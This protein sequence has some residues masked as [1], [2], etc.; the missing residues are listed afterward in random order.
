MKMNRSSLM[1]VLV[2]KVGES[3]SERGMIMTCWLIS[4]MDGLMIRG[5]PEFIG[6]WKSM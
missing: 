2:S 4:W 3:E 5:V 6:W 1:G